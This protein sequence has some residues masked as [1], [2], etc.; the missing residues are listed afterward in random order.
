MSFHREKYVP[1]GGP[2]G[3]NGGRGGDIVFV[4]D[5]NLYTLQDFRYRRVYRG[6]RGEHG[7]GQNQHGKKGKKTVIKVPLG[8]LVK[9][10]RTDEILVDLVDPDTTFVVAKGGKGGRGN[11]MF[12]TPTHRTPREWE[13]GKK[14]EEKELLLELKVLADVGLVGF[15]NAGKSTLLSVVSAAKPKIADYPFTTLTPKLGIV[16]AGEF[17]S[18]VMADIPGLID[19]AHEGKGL[20]YRFLKHIERTKLLLIMIDAGS[21]DVEQQYRAL[22]DELQRFNPSLLE[23]PMILGLSKI[24]TVEEENADIE[25]HVKSIVDRDDLPVCRFSSVTRKNLDELIQMLWQKI[26]AV[27]EEQE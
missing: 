12:A 5:G 1:K 3:G 7:R 27:H 21:E 19:G 18:F 9:D 25:R 14:G 8:T 11:A 23:K 26:N 6:Q 16:S 13:P 2:D 17:Q 24:D 4:T 10:A 22:T 20:G 15:P